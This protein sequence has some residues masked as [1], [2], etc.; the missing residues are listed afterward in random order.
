M[1]LLAII[2][3]GNIRSHLYVYIIISRHLY[4]YCKLFY[5]V[6]DIFVKV[7]IIDVS[8]NKNIMCYICALLLH[9]T[10]QILLSS[11]QHNIIRG[12][13]GKEVIPQTLQPLFYKSELNWREMSENSTVHYDGGR[14]SEL[15]RVN[16]LIWNN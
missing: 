2:Y 15:C 13:G 9:V 4:I 11:A 5:Y 3:F 16:V 7:L 8:I 1:S 14:M 12:G 10:R 6:F